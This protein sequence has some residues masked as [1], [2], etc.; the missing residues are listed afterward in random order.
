MIPNLRTKRHS[1][2]AL[3][4]LV[5][6][7]LPGHPIAPFVKPDPPQTA[8]QFEARGSFYRRQRPRGI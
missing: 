2:R 8:Q 4:L 7:S 6:E 3:Y 5:A 1:A